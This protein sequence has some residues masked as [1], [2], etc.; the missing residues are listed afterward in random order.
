VGAWAKGDYVTVYVA[1]QGI[2][3]PEE[4]Q[5]HLFDR[6]YRVD[7]SLRRRT[8]GAGLGLYL[9]RALVEAHGGRIWVHSQPGEGSTFFFTLPIARPEAGQERKEPNE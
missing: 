6:F 8:K 9:A 3:I 7:S 2:G 1:D 5:E 4:E